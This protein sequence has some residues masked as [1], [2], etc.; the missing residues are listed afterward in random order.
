MM[1][2]KVFTNIMH[3][4]LSLVFDVS[5]LVLRCSRNEETI[6]YFLFVYFPDQ[7]CV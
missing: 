1:N 6:V 5:S 3:V 2:D 7:L 4:D